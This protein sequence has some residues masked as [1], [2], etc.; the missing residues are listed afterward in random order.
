MS[1]KF[2]EPPIPKPPREI[3]PRRGKLDFDRELARQIIENRRRARFITTIHRPIRGLGREIQP[4]LVSNQANALSTQDRR[5]AANSII[6]ISYPSINNTFLLT[7]IELLMSACE[8]S[9]IWNPWK[10]HDF[11]CVGRFSHRIEAREI[12]IRLIKV[13][14]KT[15]D[16]NI[17]LERV[18]AATDK[19]DTDRFGSHFNSQ[20]ARVNQPSRRLASPRRPSDRRNPRGLKPLAGLS[21]RPLRRRQRSPSRPPVPGFRRPRRGPRTRSPR[22]DRATSVKPKPSSYAANDFDNVIR[23]SFIKL[24]ENMNNI[25]MEI[26]L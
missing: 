16:D 24:T 8:I 10:N 6:N 19:A 25:F 13:G 17:V 7:D 12:A 22:G 14:F 4:E 18:A 1:S 15:D 5:S 26:R 2:L 9:R 23:S 21:R 3:P 11:P 20:S